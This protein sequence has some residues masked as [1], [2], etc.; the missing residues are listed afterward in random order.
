MSPTNGTR[1][2][3]DASI[4]LST[5]RLVKLDGRSQLLA[6]LMTSAAPISEVY[7]V[8]RR[9]VAEERVTGVTGAGDQAQLLD[10]AHRGSRVARTQKHHPTRK[11]HSDMPL[12]RPMRA[13]RAVDDDALEVV[14]ALADLLQDARVMLVQAR[15]NRATSA[16]DLRG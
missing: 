11:P 6:G 1:P 4:W 12:L 9:T 10:Q 16:L 8:D 3:P 2:T 14:R 15:R 7:R 13:A 5:R